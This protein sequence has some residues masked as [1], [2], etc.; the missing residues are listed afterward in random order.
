M[1]IEFVQVQVMETMEVA[2]PILGKEGKVKVIF[3]SKG[4]LL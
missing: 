3:S 2:T 4:E 1:F